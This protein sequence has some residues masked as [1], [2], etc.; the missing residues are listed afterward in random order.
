MW[1]VSN[2]DAAR[3]R[4]EFGRGGY[5]GGQQGVN[6][7]QEWFIVSGLK[8]RRVT[9]GRLL[10]WLTGTRAYPARRRT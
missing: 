6:G 4:F 9:R 5:Q 1:Q 7:A 8:P 2:Y 3:R 10:S